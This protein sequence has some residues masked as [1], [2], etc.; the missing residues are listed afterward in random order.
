MNI[1]KQTCL[2]GK[3][4]VMISGEQLHWI[5]MT[6]GEWRAHYTDGSSMELSTGPHKELNRN[7]L[8]QLLG[9]ALFR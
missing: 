2:K 6:C 1:L 3:E 4:S 5:N 7:N 9:N 8:R